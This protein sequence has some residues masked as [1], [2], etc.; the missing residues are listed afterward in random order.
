[1][2][3]PLELE[4]MHVDSAGR[5]DMSSSAGQLRNLKTGSAKEM[6]KKR[7]GNNDCNK[8]HRF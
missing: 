6:K 7:N 1:M 3:V 5:H 8:V 4:G 2:E